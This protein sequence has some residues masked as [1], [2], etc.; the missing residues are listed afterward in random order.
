MKSINFLTILVTILILS[1]QK[2]PTTPTPESQPQDPQ[3]AQI[4][5]EVNAA[6]A[7]L[8]N[9]Y[10]TPP[11]YYGSTSRGTVH[12]PA[13]SMNGLATAIAQ[14]GVNGKVIVE[15]GDHWESGTVTI[16]HRVT[17]QGE[18]GA[19]L[20]FNVAG[21]G[22]SFPFPTINVLHP[23]I[24]IKNAHM[25]WIKN[26][27]MMP[28]GAKGSMGIFLEKSRLVRIEECVI[29]GFQFGVWT[30]NNSNMVRLYDNEVVGYT[31]LGVWGVVLESGKNHL[32]KG[33]YVASYAT[34]IFASD[35]YGIMEDNEMEG[36]FQGILLC[37]VQGNI[38]LP[39][40][41]M[42]KNAMPCKS[43]KFMKNVA[44]DNCL[45]YLFIDGANNNL[46]F[47]NE[48]SNPGLYD[49]E[50]AGAT[51]RFGAPSPASFNNFVINPNNN[52]ITKVCGEG[53]VALGG[54]KVNTSTD[55][56]F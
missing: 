36:G 7:E 55:P 53:N 23:A 42:L 38:Q 15:K 13:G 6:L 24:Y 18:D 33:N 9:D 12:L 56:C 48:A 35:E 43:W 54:N 25:V 51:S 26:I 44:H 2:E 52:I 3:L 10:K 40:G 50:T 17:I 22:S 39:N 37:T 19:R 16:T 14:A 5:T 8:E 1:C 45:N 32:L 47:R 20:Y 28:Q 11:H 30:S 46:L 34:N 21:P 41:S 27:E 29:K 4:E 31:E 49:V